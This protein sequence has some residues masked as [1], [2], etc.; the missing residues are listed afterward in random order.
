[1]PAL[2]KFNISPHF[3]MVVDPQDYSHVLNDWNDLSDI[4]LIAEESVHRN[5]I[6]KNFKE[7]F[8]VI[9]NKD[10]MGLSKAFDAAPIDLEGGTVALAACSLAKQLGAQSITLVGQDL[11]LS[12]SNYFV[13][14]GLTSK[15]IVETETG[16]QIRYIDESKNI[17]ETKYQDLIPI[18]GW[19]N[20]NLVTSPEYS[21]YHSQFEIFA[22]NAKNIK[23]F[24]CSVG[25]ANIKGFENRLL[26]DLEKE[27]SEN[28]F[29]F[30]YYSFSKSLN[31]AQHKDFLVKNKIAAENVLHE[32]AKI[33]KILSR[34]N[35]DEPKKLKNIDILEKK[36]IMLSKKNSKISDIV[37]DVIIKLKRAVVY[38]TTLNENLN[39]SKKFYEELYTAVSMY[40]KSLAAGIVI[41]EDI[42]KNI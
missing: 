15:S 35:R 29:N 21:V 20:E 24:N 12:N 4:S 7:I 16:S 22:S 3:V 34:K 26:D 39:L 32:I 8:T 14:G 10:V 42:E 5:F 27:F 36:V 37:S 13:S 40:K 1:M 25:G 30:D 28:N 33:K 6:N 23:L 2:A 11:A 38:V 31:I 41:I 18:L 9:T 19:S 17:P